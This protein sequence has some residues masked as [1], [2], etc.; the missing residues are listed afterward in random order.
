MASPKPTLVEMQ[1]KFTS[2]RD[3]CVQ[4]SLKFA[5]AANDR[6]A[7]CGRSI[8]HQWST[9]AMGRSGKFDAQELSHK[10]YFVGQGLGDGFIGPKSRAKKHF[11]IIKMIMGVFN[12]SLL[13]VNGLMDDGFDQRLV[14]YALA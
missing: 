1:R 11:R 12:A 13:S 4:R 8:G 7:G 6:K 5:L 9:A 2:S 10:L 3:V 14:G